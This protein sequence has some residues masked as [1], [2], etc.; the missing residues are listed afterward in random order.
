MTQKRLS[1]I[2][3]FLLSAVLTLTA[4]SGAKESL[5]LNK[6]PPDE[7]QVVKRAPLAMPPNYALRPPQPGAP[8]PQEQA[9]ID[10]ARKTVFGQG[11]ASDFALSPAENALLQKAGASHAD[12][13]IRGKVDAESLQ[14]D[15]S[16]KPVMKRLLDLGGESE[17]PATVVD[18]PKEMERLKKKESGATPSV[19]K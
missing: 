10:E 1:R 13:A 19:E 16:K 17:P 12:P 18:A 2:P 14:T 5:G 7:F 6:T 3:F 15:N 9:T 8:R 4:C 11:G